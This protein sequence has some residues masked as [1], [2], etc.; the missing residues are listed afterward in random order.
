MGG[1]SGSNGGG[2]GGSS[3]SNGGGVGGSPGSNGGGAGGSS[4]SSGNDASSDAITVCAATPDC[5]CDSFGGHAYKFCGNGRGYVDAAA[6]CD[7]QGMRLI[8]VDDEAENQWAFNGKV[9]R[10]FPSVWIGADDLAVE[11]DW[12][13]SDGT[14]FWTGKA[15]AA[16]AGPV[17]GLFN[18]WQ[19][20]PAQPDQSGDEDCAGYDYAT[21]R[22]ADLPC[23]NHN[24]YICEAY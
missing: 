18:A 20:S 19:T 13:W 2:A 8:R 21:D 17:N 11:G 12:R 7:A 3:G 5:H 10:G 23:T 22:W 4:G 15:G 14:S 9:A 1:S 6:A 24:A 16:G